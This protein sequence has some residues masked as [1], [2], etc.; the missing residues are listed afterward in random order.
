[1]P[2]RRCCLHL[3]TPPSL[4]GLN[5]WDGLRGLLLL[6]GRRHQSL[7]EG[8]FRV[9]TPSLYLVL[10]DLSLALALTSARSFNFSIRDGLLFDIHRQ[11]GFHKSYNSVQVVSPCSDPIH[12]NPP[13]SQAKSTGR[14]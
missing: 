13:I 4:C 1:M 10:A 14:I 2:S 5:S 12:S 8:L 11:S 7:A 3:L 6:A 9:P